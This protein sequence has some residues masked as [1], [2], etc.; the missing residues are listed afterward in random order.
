MAL[1]VTWGMGGRWTIGL[2][3]L[4][5][6]IG[7]TWLKAITALMNLGSI[8]K[9]IFKCKPTLSFNCY[10]IKTETE[11]RSQSTQFGQDYV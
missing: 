3:G 1:T 11:F 6:P 2:Y 5:F 10:L 4:F 9:F 7:D 8:Y